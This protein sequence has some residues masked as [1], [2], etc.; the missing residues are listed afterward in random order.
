M[1]PF[2]KKLGLILM[3][4]VFVNYFIIG[5]A[6]FQESLPVNAVVVLETAAFIAFEVGVILLCMKKPL[7]DKKQQAVCWITGELLV[8]LTVLLWGFLVH[9]YPV[10][11]N[12]QF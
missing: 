10:W 12:M 1:K 8:V 2:V 7:A 9:G 5:L 3:L 4:T 11:M 6:M